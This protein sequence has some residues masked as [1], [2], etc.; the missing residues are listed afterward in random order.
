[1]SSSDSDSAEGVVIFPPFSVSAA[2]G[3]ARLAGWL[4]QG[5]NTPRRKKM[6]KMKKLWKEEQNGDAEVMESLSPGLL[7]P[8]RLFPYIFASPPTANNRWASRQGAAAAHV[9]LEE[10][11]LR[12][13]AG[14]RYD[15]GE[16]DVGWFL[17]ASEKGALCMS[18]SECGCGWRDSQHWDVDSQERAEEISWLVKQFDDDALLATPALHTRGNS[19]TT[20]IDVRMRRS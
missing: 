8:P 3:Q 15:G 7:P 18:M 14:E 2:R 19:T 9:S 12:P 20:S 5:A 4:W 17:E 10:E 1:M 11:G 16:E 13:A 6:E